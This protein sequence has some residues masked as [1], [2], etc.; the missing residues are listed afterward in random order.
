MFADMV[1]ACF[2]ITTTTPPAVD[3][4]LIQS[5]GPIGQCF[6]SVLLISI[7]IFLKL[8]IINQQLLPTIPPFHDE[9]VVCRWRGGSMTVKVNT[10]CS[11]P[12]ILSH[13][14]LT[15]QLQARPC[16]LTE[17]PF[18]QSSPHCLYNGIRVDDWQI[19]VHCSSPIHPTPRFV[20]VAPK[21]LPCP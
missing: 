11:I 5:P 14:D 9:F 8:C 21:I 17:V 2:E 13:Q 10:Q 19:F 20:P 4:C 6:T 16:V 1:L 7:I 18:L 12:Q 15:K 3:I